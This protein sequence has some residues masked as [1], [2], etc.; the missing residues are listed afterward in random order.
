MALMSWRENGGI[1]ARNLRER[2]APAP[3]L[4]LCLGKMSDRIIGALKG[5][6]RCVSSLVHS[7]SGVALYREVFVLGTQLALLQSLHHPEFVRPTRSGKAIPK[8][9]PGSPAG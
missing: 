7:K 6:I 4:K 1:F 5:S 3:C 9:W 2:P 8:V